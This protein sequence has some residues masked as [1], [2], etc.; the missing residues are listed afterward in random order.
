MMG[1]AASA[2]IVNDA[3]SILPRAVVARARVYA[4]GAFADVLEVLF[5]CLCEDAVTTQDW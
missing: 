3:A 5:Y 4:T 1:V 2:F